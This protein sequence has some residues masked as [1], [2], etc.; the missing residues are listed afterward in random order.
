MRALRGCFVQQSTTTNIIL[1]KCLWEVCY[2]RY[3]AGLGIEVIFG[4]TFF[5]LK[6]TH[7]ESVRS[8]QNLTDSPTNN[9]NRGKNSRTSF[10]KDKPRLSCMPVRNRFT[11]T[12]ALRVSDLRTFCGSGGLG[13]LG[14]REDMRNCVTSHD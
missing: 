8:M 3:F 12:P 11:H 6:R 10:E 4:A 1:P 9:C 2:L 7:I 14:F 5:L 13:E